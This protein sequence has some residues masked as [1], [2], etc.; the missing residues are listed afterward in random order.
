MFDILIPLILFVLGLIFYLNPPKDRAGTFS[1]RTKNSLR[2]PEAFRE[3]H[4]FL[5]K[6]W[7]FSSGVLFLIYVGLLFLPLAFLIRSS[8]FFL[9]SLIVIF[10]SVILTE[11]HLE[12]WQK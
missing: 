11:R 5:G 8:I 6:A 7:L 1:Y 3:A 9:F 4:L 10:G 12:R 2:S